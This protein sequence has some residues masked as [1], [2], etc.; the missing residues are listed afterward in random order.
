MAKGTITPK[1]LQQTQAALAELWTNTDQRT[2]FLDSTPDQT[3]DYGDLSG[4]SKSGIELYAELLQNNAQ[5]LMDSIFPACQSLFSEDVWTSIIESYLRECPPDTYH[6]NSLARK[7]SAYL[8]KHAS[9]SEFAR[10][11]FIAELADFEWVEL[12]VEEHSA[13][14]SAGDYT[15]LTSQ[16]LIATMVPVVNPAHTCRDYTYQVHAIARAILDESDADESDDEG[17]GAEQA[18]AEQA[19]AEQA[20]AEQA[21]AEEADARGAGGTGL[22]ASPIDSDKAAVLLQA[23]FKRPIHLVFFRDPDTQTCR[24]LE[25]GSAA[26]TIL[27]QAQ[28]GKHTYADLLRLSLDGTPANSLEEMLEKALAVF[29]KFHEAGLFVANLKR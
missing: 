17:A 9:D 12:E 15:E 1:K 27:K 14:A 21:G 28:S 13:K 6:L 8:E 23:A 10:W 2:R 20:G 3:A 26:Q 4:L 22:S 18:G 11:P 25:L 19:G 29:G 16:E 7:F 24:T 5:G